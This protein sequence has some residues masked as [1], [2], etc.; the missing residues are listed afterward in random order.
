MPQYKSRSDLEELSKRMGS[1]PQVQKLSYQLAITK[2][3]NCTLTRRGCSMLLDWSNQGVIVGTE[4]Q[5]F[6][7]Y[8]HKSIMS[9]NSSWFFT[10]IFIEDYDLPRLLAYI[11]ATGGVR[12]CKLK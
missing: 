3:I 9:M 6:I 4:D 1:R 12:T 7:R 8:W 2:R 10:R 11:A 5:H